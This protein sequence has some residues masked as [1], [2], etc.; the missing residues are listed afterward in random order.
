MGKKDDKKRNL[1]QVSPNSP[2][3]KCS[4]VQKMSSNN[5][6]VSF[7][8]SGAYTSAI[9]TVNNDNVNVGN[10]ACLVNNPSHISQQTQ[11]SVEY[12]PPQFTR[13]SE[14]MS[15]STPQAYPQPSLPS[16]GPPVPSALGSIDNVLRDVCSKLA[17]MEQKL[18]KLHTIEQK[19][20][21]IELRVAELDKRVDGL[22]V[23]T[24]SAS[25]DIKYLNDKIRKTDDCTKN[26]REYKDKVTDIER[27]CEFLC[28]SEGDITELQNK[29][30]KVDELKQRL[31]DSEA[32]SMRDNLLFFGISEGEFNTGMKITISERGRSA[33]TT[34]AS[35][36]DVSQPEDCVETVLNFCEQILDMKDARETIKI[37]RAKNPK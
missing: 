35:N 20:C 36:R 27:S 28:R 26:V 8:S 16:F 6:D 14:F 11:R 22:D 37:E 21:K 17:R 25:K 15:D 23:K 31:I 9:N 33:G 19:L 30:N 32:R 18:E 10:Q 29:V 34:E 7:I 1:S 13:G 24:D 12:T 2:N 5:T 4:P 3:D